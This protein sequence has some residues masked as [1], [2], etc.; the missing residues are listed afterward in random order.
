MCASVRLRVYVSTCAHVYMSVSVHTH[1]LM[2]LLAQT[3]NL[4]LTGLS[5]LP[6]ALALSSPGMLNLDSLLSGQHHAN[7]LSSSP[8]LQVGGCVCACVCVLTYMCTLR[9]RLLFPPAGSLDKLL[10]S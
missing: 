10:F 1:T 6:S 3:H 2:Y 9:W 4:N 8:G 7:L 5:P